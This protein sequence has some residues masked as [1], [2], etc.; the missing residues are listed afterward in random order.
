MILVVIKDVL[1]QLRFLAQGGER[2]AEGSSKRSAA[3]SVSE[4]DSTRWATRYAANMRPNIW[5]IEGVFY[6]VQR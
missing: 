1:L 4:P 6:I 5:K 2:A 3:M